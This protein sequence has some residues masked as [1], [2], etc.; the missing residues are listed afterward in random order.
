MKT[1]KFILAT[2]GLVLMLN[3]C[4]P[5]EEINPETSQPNLEKFDVKGT[6]GGSE[7]EGPT[8][9]YGD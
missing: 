9:P 3:A 5:V 4:A 7:G 1:V 6:E 8:T 2:F